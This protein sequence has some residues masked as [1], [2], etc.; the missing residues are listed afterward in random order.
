M[1]KASRRLAHV[2]GPQFLEVYRNCCKDNKA[3][4]LKHQLESDEELVFASRIMGQ[5]WVHNIMKFLVLS[6][7]MNATFLSN[8][9]PAIM[10]IQHLKTEGIKMPEIAIVGYSNEVFSDVINPSETINRQHRPNIK[11]R[12]KK[13]MISQITNGSDHIVNEHSAINAVLIE[14]DHR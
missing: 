5:E 10:A 7:Q 2:Y 8:N 13:L 3:G 14:C 9:V 1:F 11:E 6:Y 12:S 4:F